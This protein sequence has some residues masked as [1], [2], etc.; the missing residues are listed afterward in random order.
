MRPAAELRK[1]KPSGWISSVPSMSARGSSGFMGPSFAPSAREWKSG[2]EKTHA[3]K[4]CGDPPPDAGARDAFVPGNFAS[5]SADE[6]VVEAQLVDAGA[7]GPLAGGGVRVD[8]QE[9]QLV[10]A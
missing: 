9:A 5:V 6:D 8:G 1:P 3:G 2:R 10:A 4:G 7:R